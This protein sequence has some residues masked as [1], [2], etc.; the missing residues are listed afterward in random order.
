[1]NASNMVDVLHYFFEED[2]FYSSAEQA[3]ARDETR[4]KMYSQMYGMTYK[5]AGTKSRKPGSTTYG[6]EVY[7]FSDDVPVTEDIKPFNPKK[8]PTKS[9]IPPT[10]MDPDSSRPF[11][12]DLDAPLR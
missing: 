6:G 1:M 8:N 7:D 4:K 11:G 10:Q 9:F 5:Y 2:M 12:I 3:E